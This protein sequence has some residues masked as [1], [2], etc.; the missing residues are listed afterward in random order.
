MS[1]A[2][3]IDQLRRLNFENTFNPYVERCPR[4]D[5]S[6]APD[7]RCQQ[8]IK[9]LQLAETANIDSL[10][11]GRDLGYRG[12]RRTGLAF[13]DDR[14]LQAHA[15]RWGLQ[16]RRATRGEEVT[17]RTA[18][19][20][21]HALDQIDRPVFLWN[22][23]PLHPFRDDD[24]FSNRT[25]N[26]KERQ[27]GTEI[28]VELIDLLRPRILLSIGNDATRVVQKIRGQRKVVTVRHPSFGGQRKFL[29]Q[30][31]CYNRFADA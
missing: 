1:P 26:A 10:W 16:L 18:T 7:I 29:Q 30:V 9:V 14:H 3:F 28:L 12:G 27:A 22:V 11:I 19:V 2:Q 20:L 24:S 13:T 15:N 8:L 4:F 23:F 5:L 31:A 25:H 17:E 21:W 6:N